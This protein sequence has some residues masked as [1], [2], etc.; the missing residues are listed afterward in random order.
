LIKKRLIKLSKRKEQ[1]EASDKTTRFRTV[2][3]KETMIHVR[4]LPKSAILYKCAAS[5]FWQFR[6]YLEGA[7]RKRSTQTEDIEEANRKAK[8]IYAEMLQSIHGS[9]QGKRKLSTKNALDVVAKSLFTKQ[10]FMIK[11]GE[12]NKNKNKIECY[13]YERHIK[14]YF[15][16]KDIKKINAD[17]L[18]HFKMYLIE[19]GLS[20]NT[21]KVYFNLVSKLLKEA[22]KKD[23]IT[24]VPI[25]PR[26]R[27]E[28][29]PRGYF[30]SGDYT[31]LWNAAKK[32]IGQIYSFEYKQKPVLAEQSVEIQETAIPPKKKSG[33][34]K[35]EDADKFYRSVKITVDCY[36]AILFMR[37][38][39]IRPTDLKYI[40]HVDVKLYKHD[41]ITLLE[42]R[43][44]STKRHAGYM[45]STPQ[46]VEY[47]QRIVEQRKKEGD[48]KETD[49][50]F[51]PKM[52]NREYALKELT[53]QFN[54]ILEITNLKKDNQNKQRTLYSLRHTAIVAA[55]RSG[56]PIPIIAANSR[57]S[58]DM[59][60]RFYGSHINSALEM[61]THLIDNARRRIEK[62]ERKRLEAEAKQLEKEKEAQRKLENDNV[63][64]FKK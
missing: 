45:A 4:Q 49:Y 60:N 64:I 14:P 39:Y 36:H 38:T 1:T 25:L 5:R 37:N 43:H 40:R 19:Q 27:L 26:V 6:V 16:N 50:I 33:P 35:R 56:I 57:T 12:L 30:D 24:H 58:V 15:Q 47:Y 8:L 55:I 61:G 13:V 2:P 22:V 23:Y 3:I 11:Q 46:A 21:Q 52:E 42:L 44:Q 34:K 20:K 18:E 9:E 32:H 17:A 7:Q 41:N 10:E 59:I 54:A 63:I 29:E 51:F 28:D 48:F 62:G 31:R 53:R